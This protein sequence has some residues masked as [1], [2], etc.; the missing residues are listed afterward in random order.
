MRYQPEVISVNYNTRLTTI[1]IPE[2]K[3][4]K[5]MV[6]LSK[7]IKKRRDLDGNGPTG[8]EVIQIGTDGKEF[9]DSS[10]QGGNGR[11]DRP[12]VSKTG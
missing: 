4:H 2:I 3:I 1:K 12:K 6:R 10:S 8:K 11:K 9:R 5:K 7:S